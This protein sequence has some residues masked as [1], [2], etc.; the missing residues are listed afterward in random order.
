MFYSAKRLSGSQLG[1]FCVELVD[2]HVRYVFGVLTN[3]RRGLHEL[4]DH[5]DSAI[6]DGRWHDVSVHRPLLGEHVLRVDGDVVQLIVD[7]PTHE[8]IRQVRLSGL[9]SL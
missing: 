5:L 2:G 9:E 6:D 4:I 1:V 3:D 7:P 8:F